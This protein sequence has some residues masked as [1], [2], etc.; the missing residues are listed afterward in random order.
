MCF[1]LMQGPLELEQ[2]RGE[3]GESIGSGVALVSVRCCEC[4]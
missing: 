2:F 1:S 3:R 4:I